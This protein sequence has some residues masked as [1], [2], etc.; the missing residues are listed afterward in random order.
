MINFCKSLFEKL[1]LCIEHLLC[2]FLGL[3][4][5]VIDIIIFELYLVYLTQSV[6]VVHVLFKNIIDTLN[7]YFDASYLVNHKV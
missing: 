6:E 2:F 7:F 4:V 1:L 5:E 3:Q